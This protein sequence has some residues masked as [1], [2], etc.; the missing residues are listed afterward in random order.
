MVQK[1][2]ADQFRS[3]ARDGGK[4]DGLV[5]ITK[6]A[7]DP[8]AAANSRKIRFTFS[9]AT[10]DLAGDKIDPAGWDL[11]QFKQNPVALWAHQSDLP[12]I[13]RASNVTVQNGKLVGDIEFA[14][15]DVY[16]TA[17]TIY[18]LVRGGFLKAVS[19][20]F[21]PL[22][23]AFSSDKGRPN[24]IDFKRQ[25]LLEISVCPVP[26]NPNSLAEAK[27]AGINLGPVHLLLGN[28]AARQARLLEARKIRVGVCRAY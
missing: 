6:F 25:L 7:T 28:E 16:P 5:S 23:W 11:K 22:D 10:V 13:G 8:E 14:S 2:S 3:A 21:K 26:C 27:S 24:G 9:D 19:V 4:P 17:D 18:R 12:P 20:G 1:L 15:A